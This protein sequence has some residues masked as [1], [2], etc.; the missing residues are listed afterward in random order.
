MSFSVC[1][2]RFL[3]RS[4]GFLLWLL[5]KRSKPTFMRNTEIERIKFSLCVCANLIVNVS[6]MLLVS[7]IVN[8]MLSKKMAV[9][10]ERD[11]EEA[12]ET[13]YRCWN[14][15]S[16]LKNIIDVE[17]HYRCWNT[18]SLLKHIIAVETN[19]RY[20]N[21]LSKLKHII[22][23]ET[24]YRCWNTLSLLKHIAVETH[25]RCWN[26]LSMLKHINAVETHY[27]CWNTLLMLKHII[28]VETHY[29]CWNTL[30]MSGL[31]GMVELEDFMRLIIRVISCQD[32]GGKLNRIFG[33]FDFGIQE[34]IVNTFIF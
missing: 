18:L 3:M 15:L 23:L 16:M 20:W 27:R 28:D 10:K 8:V 14:T 21:T 22:A 6:W 11:F 33:S 4:G 30:S 17:T 29:R 5:R 13:H 12:V 1:S 9:K 34:G 24:H 26:T 2:T 31:T 19:Y 7:K 25:Y 32:G